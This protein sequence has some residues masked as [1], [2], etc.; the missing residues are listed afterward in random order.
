MDLPRIAVTGSC[1]SAF[2]PVQERTKTEKLV[3]RLKATSAR[4]GARLGG[5][6]EEPLLLEA[7]CG[8]WRYRVGFFPSV[9]I[10]VFLQ[11][12]YRANSRRRPTNVVE[13]VP[14][15]IGPSHAHPHARLVTPLPAVARA[16]VLPASPRPAVPAL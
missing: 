11:S 12:H 1:R 9:S 8:Q 7:N 16:D 6:A 15:Y 4:A 5:Q 2:I 14:Y 10:Q 13:K 3:S